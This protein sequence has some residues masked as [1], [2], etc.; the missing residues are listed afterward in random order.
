M[1]AT[2]IGMLLAALY[3]SLRDIGPIWDV[4]AQG[5]FYA[6]PVLFP[7]TLVQENSETPGA[8]PWPTRWRRSSRRRATCSSGPTPSAPRRRSA[9]TARLLIPAAIIVVMAA[10]GFSVFERMAPHAAEEL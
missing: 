4:I 2:G 10:L 9:A 8:R 6:T 5:L 3:V 7:I 1:L